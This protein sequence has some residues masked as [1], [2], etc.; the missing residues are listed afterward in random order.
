MENKINKF[1][2]TLNEYADA[3]RKIRKECLEMLKEICNRVEDKNIDLSNFKDYLYDFGMC[4]PTISYDGGRHPEYDTNMYSD[5]NGFRIEGEKIIFDIED[6]SDYSEDRVS[7]DDLIDICDTFIE[8]EEDGDY[9]IGVSVYNV[10]DVEEDEEYQNK[11]LRF[12]TN[13]KWDTDGEDIDLPTR[14][15]IPYDIDD[16]EIADM[17]SDEFGFCVYGFDVTY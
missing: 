14:V 12:A 15:E 2:E 17:L 9:I 3:K 10:E 7:T 4:Y 6:C 11:P 5:V 1:K 13:I 16:D 8:C